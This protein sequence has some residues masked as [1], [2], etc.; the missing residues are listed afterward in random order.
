MDLG[1]LEAAVQAV[2]EEV[3][4][5]NLWLLTRLKVQPKIEIGILNG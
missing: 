2:V 5:G 4:V 1:G 3:E